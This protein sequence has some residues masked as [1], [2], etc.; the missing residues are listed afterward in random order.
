MEHEMLNR[1]INFE[2]VSW[3]PDQRAT[4]QELENRIEDFKEGIFFRTV[5]GKDVSQVT[6]VPKKIQEITGFK[7]MRD[8]PVDR[9]SKDLWII[10]I[11]TAMDERSKGHASKLIAK[12]V[13]WATING[14]RT[15]QT[16]VTCH[17][18]KEKMES[19]EVSSLD[20][21]MSRSLN[22]AF[23]LFR[24]VDTLSSK[25]IKDYWS[26]DE[27]SCG[28]GVVLKITLGS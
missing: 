18:L 24:S 20:D 15:I 11:A 5:K 19:G 8:L 14:Y 26:E 2:E 23:N 13:N 7:Q 9:S 28:I 4:R 17:G 21:Y 22:P 16:G 27:G 10:N 25:V 3:S 12:V 1:L 6:V